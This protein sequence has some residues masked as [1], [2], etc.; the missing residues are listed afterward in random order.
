MISF[1][2]QWPEISEKL[3][4]RFTSSL[5]NRAA[6][7]ANSARVILRLGRKEPSSYPLMIPAFA[8]VETPL[9]N[10]FFACTSGKEFSVAQCSIRNSSVIRRKKMVATSARVMLFMG[11]TVPSG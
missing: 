7:A 3:T 6:M 11:R 1:S 4:G 2:A 5:R 10:Q 9:L 8:L